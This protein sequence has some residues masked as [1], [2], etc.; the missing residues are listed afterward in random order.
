MIKRFSQIFGIVG[1]VL[2][3]LPCV[4]WAADSIYTLTLP[5]E[6]TYDFPSDSYYAP[7]FLF[8]SGV[9]IV[10]TIPGLIGSMLVRKKRK[11]AG[12]LMLV[13]GVLMFFPEV[14]LY[15][16]IGPLLLVTAG[17]LA[18]TAE[19]NEDPLKLNDENVHGSK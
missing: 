16:R 10:V 6:P 12:I 4:I 1:V 11:L 18:L 15:L 13:S 14:P 7:V 17:V 19:K 3:L 5:V 8:V 9:Y 2:T